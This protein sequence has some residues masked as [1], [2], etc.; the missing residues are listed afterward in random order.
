MIRD[1]FVPITQTGG[2]ASALSAAVALARHCDA[3]LS[4]LQPVDLPLPTP[5]PW[6]VTPDYVLDQM[7][8][9][10]RDAARQHAAHLRE[11]L[12]GEDIDWDVRVDEALFVDPPRSLARQARHADLLVMAAPVQGAQDADEVRAYFSAMLFESGRPVLVAPTHHPV[13]LPFRRALLAWKPTREATRALHDALPLLA[14]ASAVDVV[15]VHHHG[16]AE[17]EAAS[18]AAVVAHL[19]H[20]GLHA[21]VVALARPP[22]HTVASTLLQRAAQ[23]EAGLLIAGGY[24]H[25]RLREW[26]LGGTTRELLQAMHLPILFSH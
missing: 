5:S 13:E 25:S 11:R 24:G 2:D 6:G 8:D 19:G 3:H 7:H 22:G 4:V 12:A 26:M 17:R 14:D 1:L 16:E 23:S 10:L 21:N 20:H 18:A 9:Q 15:V